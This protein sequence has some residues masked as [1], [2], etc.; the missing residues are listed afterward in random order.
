MSK[1]CTICNSSLHTTGE[2]KKADLENTDECKCKKPRVEI[3][4]PEHTNIAT[5]LDCGHDVYF[6]HDTWEHFTRNYH[7]SGYPYTTL[8]CHA[9][10]RNMKGSGKK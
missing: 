5:C 6:Q 1:C 2:H 8:K 4:N 7:Q 9:P 3:V 10:V